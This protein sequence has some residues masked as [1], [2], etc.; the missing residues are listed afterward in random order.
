MGKSVAEKGVNA[1]VF[2]SHVF[3]KFPSA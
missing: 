2:S 1:Y 3:W